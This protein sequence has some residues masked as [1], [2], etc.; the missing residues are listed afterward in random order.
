ME[1]CIA[2]FG[3]ACCHRQDFDVSS[4]RCLCLCRLILGSTFCTILLSPFYF[5]ACAYARIIPTVC[6]Y[7]GEVDMIERVKET[8][9][10][11]Q[12]NPKAIR[13]CCAAATILEGILL[14]KSLKL[15][16]EALVNG[17]MASTLNFT[18]DDADIGDACL[19]SLMEAKMKDIPELVETMKSE[20]EEH[21]GNSARFPSAFEIPVYLFYKS[22]ADGDVDEAAY[23]K[24]VRSNINAGGEVCLRATMIG[25]IFGAAAGSVPASFVEKFPKA[26]MESVD[27][28]IKE[29]CSALN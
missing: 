23:I 22:M 19:F 21:G 3:Y 5:T 4:V 13:F 16:L 27:K 20:D 26:T 1:F 9:M 8:V 25:A 10:I 6:L 2:R 11:Y 29:I 15:S 24:A 14:G 18:M 28:A 12:N 17:A 7:A